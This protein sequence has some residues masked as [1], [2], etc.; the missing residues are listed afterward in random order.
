MPQG[1]F[2][3]FLLFVLAMFLGTISLVRGIFTVDAGS[4]LLGIVML[5]CGWIGAK[6][7]LV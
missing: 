2:L 3:L 6:R 7:L 1:K 5:L 4:M